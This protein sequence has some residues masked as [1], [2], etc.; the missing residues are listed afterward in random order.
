VASYAYEKNVP[1]MLNPVPSRELHDEFLSKI[2]Y[3]SPNEHEAAGLTGIKIRNG[4][5]GVDL[6]VVKRASA[7]LPGRGVQNV[8]ITLGSSGVSFMNKEKFIYEPIAKVDEVAD[9]TAA[10]DS[11]TGA[12]CIAI[13]M[14]MDEAE[15]LQFA[16]Y[17]AAITVSRMGAQPSLP[18]YNEVINFVN[19]QNNNY[20]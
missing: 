15:A 4:E 19:E 11:F 1:V 18:C 9:P 2:T 12:L 3:I 16:K 10:G 7:S 17:T 14:G 6:D 13:C 20:K 5:N 8:I